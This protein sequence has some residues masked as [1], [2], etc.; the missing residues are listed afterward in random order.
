[1]KLAMAPNRRRSSKSLQELPPNIEL[2]R[3]HSNGSFRIDPGPIDI[4]VRQQNTKIGLYQSLLC[5]ILL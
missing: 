5:V 4:E 2:E 3:Q 1:M